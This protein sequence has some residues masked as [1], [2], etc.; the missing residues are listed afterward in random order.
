MRVLEVMTEGVQTVP[1]T[2]SASQAWEI[3]RQQGIRHLVVTRGRD[4]VGV[5]SERDAGG[6]S[7]ASIRA[8]GTVA[9]LMTAHV[10]TVAPTDTVRSVANLMRGR[11]IG[12]VPVVDHSRLVGIVTLSDL[13][14]LLGRGVDRPAKPARRLAT[15][16]VPH[17]PGGRAHAA[18]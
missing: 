8:G 17:R 18:W 6:R 13:L 15:H 12:C 2:M 10:A 14:E 9:D 16:R 11:T 5:L 3:M 7:G 4:V 1:P